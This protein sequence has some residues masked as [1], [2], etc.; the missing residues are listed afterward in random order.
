MKTFV[1]IA[2][3]VIA[4]LVVIAIVS[5]RAEALLGA[6]VWGG[7]AAAAIA[8]AKSAGKAAEE[9]KRDEIK[10]KDLSGDTGDERDA[11]YARLDAD[12]AKRTSNT[13]NRIFRNAFKR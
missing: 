8:K 9:Q 7:G 4:G 6:I 1:V 11:E 10:D 3:L 2:V 5:G 13:A 12:A